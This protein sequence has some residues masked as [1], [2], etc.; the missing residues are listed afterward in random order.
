MGFAKILIDPTEKGSNL[1]VLFDFKIY[2]IMTL[3]FECFATVL[4]LTLFLSDYLKGQSFYE[5]ALVAIVILGMFLFPYFNLSMVKE[6]K[7]KF[8]AEARKFIKRKTVSEV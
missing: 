2:Y 5:L 6:T 4:L 1:R 7:T 3:A 8:I